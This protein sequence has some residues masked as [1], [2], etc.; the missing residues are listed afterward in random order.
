MLPL[1]AKV[2]SVFCKYE[3]Y[4]KKYREQIINITSTAALDI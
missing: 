1:S 4:S 3:R 2:L